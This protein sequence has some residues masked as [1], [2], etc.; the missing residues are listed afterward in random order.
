M[1]DIDPGAARHRWTIAVDVRDL[2]GAAGGLL[3]LVGAAA[4][5]WALAVIAI[6]AG[7]AGLA[8]RLSRR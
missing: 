2:V 3:I 5:H 7:L 8:W 1:S 4:L 6:G